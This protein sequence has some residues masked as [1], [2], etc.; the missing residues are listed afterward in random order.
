M[1]CHYGV[2][3]CLFVCLFVVCVCVCA[4]LPGRIIVTEV[5]KV[6]HEPGVDLTKSQALV[7]RLQNGLGTV[8]MGAE[9]NYERGGPVGTTLGH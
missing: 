2:F 9:I 7:W 4:D 6:L 5:D 8:G 1:L 3:V